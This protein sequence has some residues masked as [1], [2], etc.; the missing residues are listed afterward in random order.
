MG[1][2]PVVAEDWDDIR[3]AVH[4]ELRVHESRLLVEAAGSGRRASQSP[5]NLAR[6]TSSLNRRHDATLTPRHR[7]ESFGGSVTGIGQI[8][9]FPIFTQLDDQNCADKRRKHPPFQVVRLRQSRAAWKRRLVSD[10]EA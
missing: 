6:E 5:N 3:G 4:V 10:R 7:I 1:A 2:Q 9:V 8:R